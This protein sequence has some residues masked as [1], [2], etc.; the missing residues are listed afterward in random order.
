MWPADDATRQTLSTLLGY[1]SILAWLSAQIPQVYENYKNSSVEALALPFLVSWLAGDATNLI[2]CI[3][4]HQLPFQTYLATYFVGIDIALVGQFIYYSRKNPNRSLPP[5]SEA[6]PHVHAP[7]VYHYPSRHRSSHRKKKRQRT[8]DNGK[9]HQVG[10]DAEDPMAHSWMSS[11][12]SV[13]AHSPVSTRPTNSRRSTRFLPSR[14]ASS[15]QL[16][17]TE[18]SHSTTN[19]E[20]PSPVLDEQRG[21]TLARPS[22]VVAP[23]LE[24]ISGSPASGSPVPAALQAHFDRRAEVEA[25]HAQHRRQQQQY[26]HH[27]QQQHHNNHQQ[28]AHQ[29]SNSSSSRSRP[30]QPSRRTSMLFLSVGVLFT[31]SSMSA[32]SPT[33]ATSAEVKGMAWSTMSLPLSQPVAI[34]HVSPSIHPPILGWH[35]PA[36]EEHRI[37]NRQLDQ[38]SDAR[39][40]V[41][42]DAEHEGEAKASDDHGDDKARHRPRR[43]WERFIGRTS[44][45]LCT[46][47][48]LTSRLPQI[49]QNFRR[50]SV[51]GLSMMLF[52]SAFTGNLLYVGSI[53]TNPNADEPGYLLESLPYLLGSGGTLCFDV[54]I[55]LQ[56]FLYSEKRRQNQDRQR[57]KKGRFALYAEEEAALLQQSE[58]D[59]DY[60]DEGEEHVTDG[61]STVGAGSRSVSRGPSLRSL[62]RGTRRY[63]RRTNSTEMD[64]RSS[65]S[66]SR[67]S[68]KRDVADSLEDRP[69][70]WTGEDSHSS[71]DSS[72]DGRGCVSGNTSR[73]R[74]RP[75]SLAS[76]ALN[77]IPEVGE[78]SVT[79]R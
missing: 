50:R 21:R 42:V 6:F 11:A 34:E 51:A 47:L 14:Q 40:S 74:T 67:S 7:E 4:T 19:T 13:V 39:S 38:S 3:L 2:G 29:R 25:V 28:V 59:D 36:S 43:D 69:F 35:Q 71:R 75:A 65:K 48:Y 8:G 55:V 60:D 33:R 63:V 17:Y 72:I 37:R 53:L 26:Q 46:T 52:V 1:S 79:I 18:S 16:G 27:Q 30:P 68:V 56:H 73:S 66:R 62:P 58:V 15:Q 77:H 49:W 32:K 64:K 41:T 5:L 22:R 54:T 31:F 61:G 10:S 45:W 9:A 23:M 12:S 78:S 57:R 70:D 24:T 20:P 76:V 44:A